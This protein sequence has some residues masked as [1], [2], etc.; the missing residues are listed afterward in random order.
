MHRLSFGRWGSNAGMAYDSPP[1]GASIVMSLSR[2]TLF[3][4]HPM[5]NDRF[6]TEC[7]MSPRFQVH[8]S[9]ETLDT[10]IHS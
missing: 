10:G 1:S 5:R 6:N 8:V 9:E 7:E 3:V 2:S 4:L